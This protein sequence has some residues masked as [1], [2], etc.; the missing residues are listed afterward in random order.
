[1]PLKRELVCPPGV[2]TLHALND[3]TW[4]RHLAEKIVVL[5]ALFIKEVK[6]IMKN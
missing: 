2:S 1:M 6:Y 4:K 5:S 3:S